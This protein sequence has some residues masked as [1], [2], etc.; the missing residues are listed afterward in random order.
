MILGRAVGKNEAIREKA[1]SVFRHLCDTGEYEL[2][3]HWLRNHIHLFGLFGQRKQEGNEWFLDAS[4]TE[5]LAHEMA[6]RWRADHLSG[7]L[8]PCRW[9]LQP[10]YTMID[11][12]VWDE[13]CRQA[14][15]DV[16]SD[17]R[18][19]DGFS[20]MLYGSHFSTDSSTVEKMCNY[21]CYI[22]RVK[23][24]LASETAGELHETVRTAL[25]KA[26]DGGF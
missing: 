2:T 9:S 15:E 5:V 6:Q 26:I 11:T 3:E 16:L 4:K 10:V 25:Q 24:R 17:G 18:A 12:Q 21:E 7:E 19:L 23:S 1:A 20:L 8:I 22:K 14:L 13:E